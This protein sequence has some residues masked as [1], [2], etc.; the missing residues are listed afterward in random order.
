MWVSKCSHPVC[1]SGPP[2]CC[3]LDLKCV[4]ESVCALVISFPA[5]VCVINLLIHWMKRWHKIKL[6]YRPGGYF[7]SKHS[8]LW[9]RVIQARAS[10]SRGNSDLFESRRFEVHLFKHQ[11]KWITRDC[12]NL[13]Y[14]RE[15]F[16]SGSRGHLCHIWSLVTKTNSCCTGCNQSNL[17]LRMH[18]R[19][20]Y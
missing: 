11:K 7:V 4:W 6:L 8:D 10:F 2:S 5:S 1:N 13:S 14:T 15:L 3:S 19:I 16:G 9:G 20:E 12:R 18:G 17:C